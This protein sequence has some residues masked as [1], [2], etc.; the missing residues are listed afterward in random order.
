MNR[1]KRLKKQKEAEAAEAAKAKTKKPKKVRFKI[2]S[3]K[4][5]PAKL[6]KHWSN[7]WKLLMFFWSAWFLDEVLWCCIKYQ[8]PA[9]NAQW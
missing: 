6:V 9:E 1:R 4:S 2:Q 3:T 5:A 8:T 7:L